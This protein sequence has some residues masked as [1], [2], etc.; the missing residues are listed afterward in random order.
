MLNDL[1]HLDK[2]AEE[3]V[4]II[5]MSKSC[6]PLGV[7]EVS[8][9]SVCEAYLNPREVFVRLLLVGAASFVVVHNH[10]SGNPSPSECD[11]KIT[12]RLGKCAELMGIDMLDHIIVGKTVY[13][14]RK[15]EM[16][17]CLAG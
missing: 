2:L 11:K 16:D 7:F 9:G 1:F 8:H 4:Y 6:E 13:S 12:E 17:N 5:A 14:F 10:P 15:N 3:Y